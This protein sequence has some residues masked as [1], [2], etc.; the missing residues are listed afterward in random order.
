MPSRHHVTA[1]KTKLFHLV[2]VLV[3]RSTG[4]FVLHLLKKVLTLSLNNEG[5]S[6]RH[7]FS[8]YVFFVFFQS[9]VAL[10]YRVTAFLLKFKPYG[11]S[12]T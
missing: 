5:L 2:T 3:K 9:K 1:S 10:S 8:G 4:P 12:D 6:A 11:D 7:N